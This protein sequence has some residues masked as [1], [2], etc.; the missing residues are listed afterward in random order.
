[1]NK[2]AIAI[3]RATAVIGGTLALVVGT[4][5]ANLGATAQLTNNNLA[6]ATASLFVST[7]GD[8]PTANT[9]AGFTLTEVVP[10]T[11]TTPAVFHLDNNG[12]VPL[13]ITVST[14]GV[15]AFT[16]FTDFSKV[17]VTIHD[18]TVNLDTSTTL[19]ALFTSDVT[20]NTNGAIPGTTQHDFTIS[21]NIH[22]DA[23]TGSSASV[24]PYVLTFTGTQ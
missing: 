4:T 17:D 7:R 16:G 2:R 24:G 10:G 5:F 14:G 15:P 12:G 1:M 8:P 9:A 13:N 23:V 6:S 11:P 20:L 19:A 22:T 3:A 21:Y 18:S